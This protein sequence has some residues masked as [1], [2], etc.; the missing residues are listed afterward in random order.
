MRYQDYFVY[1][2][3]NQRHTVPYIEVTNG[4][5][6]RLWE[7][8]ETRRTHFARQYNT[9]KL[10]HFAAFPDSTSAIAREKKL[11]RWRR[12]KKEALIVKSNPNGGI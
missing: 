3:A 1:I 5:E 8:G 9:D 2:L 11:K 7:H 10:I 4:L 6:R 12:S